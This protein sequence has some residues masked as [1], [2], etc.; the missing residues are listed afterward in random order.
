MTLLTK[1]EFARYL[2][3]KPGYVTQLGNAGRLVMVGRKVDVEASLKLIEATR[4]PAKQGVAERH[5]KS[6]Q[7]KQKASN[8]D[9]KTEVPDEMDGAGSAYQLAKA[10]KEKY[11]ALAAKMA[12]E[13][14]IKQLL[15]VDDVLMAVMDGDTII[16]SRLES[17]PDMLSPQLAAETDEHRVRAIL[18]EQIEY[19]L[20]ELS[21]SFYK[22]IK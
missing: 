6:R 18:I 13:R 16:R 7:Q 15:Y 19:L 5:E 4:D 9:E 21:G 17:L 20:S 8:Q 14:D 12:Y 2:N 22:L 10:V 11:N 3:V 1:S